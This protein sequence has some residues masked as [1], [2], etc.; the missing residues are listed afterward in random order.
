MMPTVSVWVFCFIPDIS[1]LSSFF[2][3]SVLLE[4]CHFH[5]SFQRLLLLSLPFVFYFI[6]FCSFLFHYFSLLWVYFA[7]CFVVPWG[8]LDHQLRPFFFSYA[9]MCAKSLQSNSLRPM[10]CSPPGSSVHGISQARILEWVAMPS[11]RGSSQPRDQTCILYIS[12]IG[13][14]VLYH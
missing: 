10:D 2:P 5:W 12:C 7:L 14:Q 4:D 8:R 3:L 13:S 6:D 1:N 9:C 11:S